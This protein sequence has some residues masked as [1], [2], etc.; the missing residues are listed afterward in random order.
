MSDDLVNRIVETAGG[1]VLRL[2]QLL[3]R[4]QATVATAHRLGWQLDSVPPPIAALGTALRTIEPALDAI[5]ADPESPTA[6]HS[7]IEAVA[8][9]ANALAALGTVDF[10]AALN[11]L[12]FASELPTQL[13][14][15]AVANQYPTTVRD[16]TDITW[17]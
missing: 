1:A 2:G 6:W 13:L 8:S 12:G 10:G 11:G 9:G 5:V 15:W 14:H 7:L 3:A 4:D 17:Q 16:T